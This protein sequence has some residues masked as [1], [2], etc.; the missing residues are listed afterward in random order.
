MISALAHKTEK[1]IRFHQ[2]HA[3]C[4]SGRGWPSST[5]IRGT[6]LHLGIFFESEL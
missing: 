1:A 2:A 4:L 6:T 3:R 5:R